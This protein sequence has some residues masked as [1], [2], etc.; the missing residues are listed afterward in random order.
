VQLRIALDCETE[1]DIAIRLGIA[2]MAR[3][4][5]DE[6]DWERNYDKLSDA[7]GRWLRYGTTILIEFDT[8]A[9]TCIVVPQPP[10]P[11]HNP[12]PTPPSA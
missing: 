2:E 10:G 8:E 7:C 1:I 4:P 12:V 9:G 3:T 11:G 5:E 6:W